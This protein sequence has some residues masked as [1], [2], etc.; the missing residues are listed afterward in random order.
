MERI[1][2]R[3]ELLLEHSSPPSSPGLGHIKHLGDFEYVDQ[4]Q[5][6]TTADREGTDDELDFVLFAPS[7]KKSEAS[8]AVA[9]IRIQTPPPDDKDP[10]FIIPSRSEAY[11]FT[12]PRSA[13]QHQ[14]FEA[15]ALLGQNVISR[16]RSL[17]PG[18][19]YAWKVQRIAVSKRQLRALEN[20]V[21][22]VNG[23][24][25]SKHKRPG[26]KAR[27]KARTKLQATQ[28]SQEQQQKT[29]ELKE[30]AER[31]K[32]T[33]RNREKKAKKKQREKVKK[34]EGQAGHVVMEDESDSE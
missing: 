19:G 12:G 25:P 6:P 26:K 13:E 32:R 5:G 28:A 10:R 3:S 18:N 16:S 1:V 24:V 27:V 8:Q 9:K 15:A 30:A 4:K 22:T 7:A 14:N 17:V 34:A 21:T 29:D 2:D 33:R 23:D 11:Y 20:H 31:E